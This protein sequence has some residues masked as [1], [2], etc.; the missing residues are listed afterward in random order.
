MTVNHR[1]TVSRKAQPMPYTP[2]NVDIYSAA[3]AGAVA[4]ICS[5][6]GSAI[7]D[8]SSANY[9]NQ[10]AA[11]AAWAQAI[12]TV[13][14]GIL[15]LPTP[16]NYDL[17][18]LQL[19]SQAYHS[20]HPIAP[21]ALP[22]FATQANW[23]I[24]ARAVIAAVLQGDANFGTQFITPP[25]IPSQNQAMGAGVPHIPGGGGQ[26]T[27]L[28]MKLIAKSSGMFR[29][30]WDICY[31]AVA[32]DT[33]AVTTQIYTDAVA[34]VPLTLGAATYQGFGSNGFAQPGNVAVNDN[35]L[36]LSNAVG[37]ITIAG[38]NGGFIANTSTQTVGTAATG[39]ITAWNGIFGSAGYPIPG[40]K[41]PTPI[42][43]TFLVTLSV[44]NTGGA[45]AIQVAGACMYE[46]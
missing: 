35:G 11:A 23:T 28:A 9:S 15:P 5:P 14:A 2:N 22:A 3:F 27:I 38:D 24:P 26:T 41:R 34:G 31:N 17:N 42:G 44:T 30:G 36:Y 43:Q 13:W 18:C 16:N 45:R 12:D 8:P 21:K 37:G 25:S 7:I 46:L 6:W 1:K 32:T 40:D 4:T 20:T 33:I 39:V 29:I 19:M 10:V